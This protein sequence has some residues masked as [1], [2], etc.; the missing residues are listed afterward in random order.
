MFKITAQANNE[1]EILLYDVITDFTDEE[2]GFISAKGLI[3]KVKALGNITNITLRI[4]SLGGDIF[5]AQAMY[6]YLKTHPANITVMIDGIAASAA[7]VVAMSGNKIIMP[8]NALLM[9]HNPAGGVYGEAEDMRDSAEILDKVRDTIA[10]V[11]IARTGL[12]RDKVIEMMNAETWL[13]AQEAKALKFCDEISEPI[14]IAA[15]ANINS[16]KNQL[17]LN[18]A[19]NTA[20]NLKEEAK[21]MPENQEIRTI[22]DLQNAYPELVNTLRDSAIQGERERLR[23]LDSLNAPGREAIIARAKYEEPKDA[24]DIAIE[25]LQADKSN[26][27]INA[28][29]QDA[30]VANQ[31]LTPQKTVVDAQAESDRAATLIANHINSMRGY[32]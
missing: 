7:S 13:S 15:R 26:A 2:W 6:S 25:L 31:A 4:N 8:E 12:E 19:T 28:M 11:Y 1:A 27:Q 9:I 16:I 14:K 5:E 30:Q 22:A 23:T 21:V 32:K 29:H 24:R 17:L 18:T 3:D 20:N 10:N